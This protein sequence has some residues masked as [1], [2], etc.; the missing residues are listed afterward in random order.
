MSNI[1]VKKL[2]HH[3]YCIIGDSSLLQELVSELDKVHKIPAQGNPDFF[4]KSYANFVIDD[5]RGLIEFHEMRPVHTSGKK[6]IALQM[7]GITVEAQ[8]ALLKLLEEPA[9]YAHFFIIVPSKHLLLPT[10]QSRLSFVDVQKSHSNSQ[11]N[12]ISISNDSKKTKQSGVDSKGGIADDFQENGGFSATFLKSSISKR[13]EMVKKIAD[14]ISDEKRPKR[15]AIE[16]LDSL[17]KAILKE[18]GVKQCVTSLEA[19]QYAR[20]YMNDRAPSFKML[21]EYVALRV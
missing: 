20:A 4:Q 15:H 12:Q 6:I 8:N 16:F 9:E 21:L 10:V 2:S 13:L 1:L 5:A 3:A 7:D 11:S 14:D 17:E 19:I 18:R